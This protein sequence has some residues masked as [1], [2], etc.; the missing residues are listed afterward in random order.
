VVSIIITVT[1]ILLMFLRC[2]VT[3][4]MGLAALLGVVLLDANIVIIPQYIAGG[5]QSFALLAVPFF[6]LAGNLMNSLGLTRRIFGLA[7]T[8]VGHIKGGLAQVNV[9]ASII[10]AGISG[11]ALADAA[12][13][14]VVEVAAM[15]KAGY[16]KS[17]A[18]AVTLASASIGPIIPPSIVMVIYGIQAEVSIGK[19]LVAGILPGLVIG[20]S[21]M[22]MNYYL[23]VRGIETCPVT[24]RQPFGM[25]AKSVGQNILAV[26]APVFI[27]GGLI[28]GI[29]TPTEAGIVAVAFSILVGFI[30]KEISF[31][32]L[33]NALMETVKSTSIIMILIGVSSVVSWIYTYERLPQIAALSILSLSQNKYVILLLVNIFLLFMGCLIEPIPLLLIATP[34]L[35]PLMQQIGVDL[36]HFGVII[37]YN[38]T[39]GMITPPMGV[40]LYVMMKVVDISFEELVKAV[41]PFLIPLIG[42]LFLVT[43]FP[44]ISLALVNLFW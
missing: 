25:V 32:E 13:L 43:Y 29:V 41:L 9:V 17:F 40:G 6:L 16:R 31:K 42:T 11:A 7:Q 38:I 4:S 5:T 18:T 27:V 34:I 22:V 23:A 1:F 33:R 35:A 2:P 24:P 28:S 26:L 12:G 21:L 8:I 19:L 36:V 10:F 20:G 30:Y 14:G 3:F 37:C 44:A 39:L 15:T